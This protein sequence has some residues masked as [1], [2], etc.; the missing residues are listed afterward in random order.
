MAKMKKV[1]FI[2]LIVSI[3]YSI[4]SAFTIKEIWSIADLD[5]PESVVYYPKE[6]I[7]FVS[8]INGEPY[9]H[10]KNGY[11]SK[12]KPNGDIVDKKWIATL[13]A[14]KG[15]AIFNNFLYVADINQL[16]VIDIN[17]SEIVNRVEIPEADFLNDVEKDEFGNIYISDSSSNPGVIYKYSSGKVEKWISSEKIRRP[18]GLL[19]VNDTL[20]VGSFANGDLSKV[21]LLTKKITFVGNFINAIDGITIVDSTNIILSNWFNKI[22]LV[23]NFSV[24]HKIKCNH[25]CADIFYLKDYQSLLIPTFFNNKL[26]AYKI[27]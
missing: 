17:K 3:F 2:L 12:I 24:S 18:N 4:I 19:S 27:Q 11:I 21:N 1:F 8:N 15:M 9:E 6:D 16:V 26:I 25:N 13:D 10:D 14:P 20:Y 7:I 22:A 5:C 23:D